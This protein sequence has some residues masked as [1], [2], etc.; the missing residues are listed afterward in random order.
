MSGL[1]NAAWNSITFLPN[2]KILPCCQFDYT[3]GLDIA[4]FRGVDTFK[5]IQDTMLAGQTPL[6]CQMCFEEYQRK[7]G[8]EP[9]RR[10]AIEFL[11]LR[12]TNQCNYACRFC[13]PNASSMWN[14]IIQV[15]PAIVHTDITEHLPTIINP[16]LRE[17]YFTGG[18]PMLNPDH[19]QILDQLIAADYGKNIILRYNSNLSTLRYKQQHI[20]NYW[21]KFKHID[22]KVSLDAVGSTLEQIRTGARWELIDQNLQELITNRMPN[23][24]INVICTVSSLNVWFLEPLVKYCA[25][26]NIP[27]RM[28]LLND[29]DIL[30]INHLPKEFK[31]Q[32]HQILLDLGQHNVANQINLSVD[33]DYFSAFIAHVMLLDRINGENLYGILPFDCYA[34][35]ILLKY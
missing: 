12:N 3:Q 19:W 10:T 2:G 13:G 26:L 5:S 9:E 31:Q 22:F 4:E 33:E 29:P 11:D 20:S 16:K 8:T 7:F 32:A 1:C 21:P 15:D 28:D 24:I 27:L 6:G 35:Q 14:R 25:D 17:L 30:S 18:E 34:R 23:L